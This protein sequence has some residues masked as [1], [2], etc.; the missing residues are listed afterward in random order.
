MK[1][2]VIKQKDIE[3]KWYI[4]DATGVRL[5]TLATKIAGYLIGKHKTNYTPNLD[6][7][8][9]IIVIN[10]KNI[11]IFPKKVESKKYY[12]HSNYP[13][14]LT[15]KTYKEMKKFDSTRIIKL[16]VKG[17]LPQNK[18]R[19]LRLKHLF[20]YEEESHSHEAQKPVKLDL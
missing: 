9:N 16:A 3:K 7:G 20:V 4:I 18:L 13:G 12:R 1:T 8:D 19:D 6:C 17:M 14:G 2:K 11:D 5:G 15:V 10:S